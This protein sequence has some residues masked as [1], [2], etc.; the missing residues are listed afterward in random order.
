M[1]WLIA[2]GIGGVAGI[3]AYL[4]QFTDPNTKVAW[5]NRIFG[6]RVVTAFFVGVLCE[7]LIADMEGFTGK[8]RYFMYAMSGWGGA[9]TVHFFQEVFRA[10]VQRFAGPSAPARDKDGE[11]RR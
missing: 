6:A 11:V 9:E 1:G 8:A 7:W 4:Q 10:A 2:G 5:N 3:V